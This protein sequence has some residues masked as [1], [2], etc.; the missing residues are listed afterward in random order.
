MLPAASLSAGIG[1]LAGQLKRKTQLFF[2]AVDSKVSAHIVL[3]FLDSGTK[4]RQNIM[5]VK[6][7]G[8]DYSHYEGQEWG[9]PMPTSLS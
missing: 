2:S 5:V 4:V 9:L 6:A 1:Q 3:G 8:R 7:C